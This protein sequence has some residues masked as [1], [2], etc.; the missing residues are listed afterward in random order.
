[1]T[2]WLAGFM[3]SAGG[4]T[5]TNTT[6]AGLITKVE[7]IRKLSRQEANRGLPVR[8][9]GIVTYDNKEWGNLFVQDET[10]GIGSWP[11]LEGS[12]VA[13]GDVVD[14]EGVTEQSGFGP[15]LRPSKITVTGK[16]VLPAPSKHSYG[17][18]LTGSDDA[19]WIEVEGIVHKAE[20]QQIRLLIQGGDTFAWVNNL[21]VP[22]ADALVDARIRIRGVCHPIWNDKKQLTGFSLLTPGTNQITVLEAAP[23][24]PFSIPASPIAE[25]MLYNPESATSGTRIHRVKIKGVATAGG[26]SKFFVQDAS[27]GAKVELAWPSS[28]TAGDEVDVVGFPQVSGYAVLLADSL[29]RVAGKANLPAATPATAEQ[30]FSGDLDA[31]RVSVQGVLIEP[32]VRQKTA[33]PRL[34]IDNRIVRAFFPTGQV[35]RVSIAS[36]SLVEVRGVCSVPGVAMGG[37]QALPDIW[38]NSTTDLVLLKRA[39]WWKT[40]YTLGLLGGLLTLILS[41]LVWVRTLRRN[42]ERRTRELQHEIAERAK[43][44]EQVKKAH[45]LLIEASRKAGMAE[46]ATN[47]LHNVGNVLNS[48][49]VSCNLVAENVGNSNLL[50]LEKL[51]ELIEKSSSEPAFLSTNPKGRMIPGYLRQLVEKQA[52]E[53]KAVIEEVDSLKKNISH[54]VG[55]VS[56]QQNYAK[57]SGVVELA[58]VSELADDA[59]RLT[60]AALSRHD[61]KVVRQYDAT[62][63]ILVDKHKALQI[64]VNLLQNAKNACDEGSQGEKQITVRIDG[65]GT[66]FVKIEVKDNGAGIAPENLTRMFSHGFT[67]RKDGHGFGLHSGAL[68]AK[69]MGGSL[70]ARS[71]GLGRGAVFTLELP[72]TGAEATQ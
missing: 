9:H 28:V 55:I 14:Y 25:L 59:L 66:D 17:F 3:R 50:S 4:Q 1:M 16:S 56:M 44:E 42:V 58:P 64:L 18:I 65:R 37:G 33:V 2:C 21:T 11:W 32:V 46:V 13:A 38:L 61:I 48:V 7:L 10:G 52:R 15:S 47:V 34:Q 35:A 31:R 53:K 26:D 23:A 54:I 51:A 20:G 6:V 68:A 67:T 40:E 43:V 24:D 36:G 30:L 39:P 62:G 57:V 8:I 69:E 70:T 63:A 72:R 19:Q 5:P 41:G 27:S 45:L 12:K 60:G 22:A 71:E 49:N 29:V